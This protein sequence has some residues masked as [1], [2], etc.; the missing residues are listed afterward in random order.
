MWSAVRCHHQ[1]AESSQV[2]RT[3]GVHAVDRGDLGP[4]EW[5]GCDRGALPGA[6]ARPPSLQNPGGASLLPRPHL[7]GWS[8]PPRPGDAG[9]G[10]AASSAMGRG[11]TTT[12]QASGLLEERL[13]LAPQR[14]T[15]ETAWPR[16]GGRVC[17]PSDVTA[18]GVTARGMRTGRPQLVTPCL[19]GACLREGPPGQD[20][21]TRLKRFSVS[22]PALGLLR[23][24]LASHRR[25][26]P[27]SD[28]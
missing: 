5:L 12:P 24:S 6:A 10:H 22:Q 26:L 28:A 16:E 11:G 3:G 20:R 17:P 15:R 9:F 4:G 19:P 1:R 27:E 13:G 23:P 18:C 2:Q 14:G 8:E 7:P 25:F 21:R